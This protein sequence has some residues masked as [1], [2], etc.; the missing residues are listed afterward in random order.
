MVAILYI[1]HNAVRELSEE[2]KSTIQLSEDFRFFL[3][4]SARIVERAL[5]EVDVDIDYSRTG[6]DDRANA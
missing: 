5:D 1:S 3:D 6:D 4:H 2:E